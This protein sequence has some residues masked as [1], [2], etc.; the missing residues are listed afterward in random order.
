M[1]AAHFSPVDVKRSS[2]LQRTCVPGGGWKSRSD[3]IAARPSF[4]DI[5]ASPR[6]GVVV[7]LGGSG[8]CARFIA[9]A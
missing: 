7:A 2:H 8:H 4:H 5:S 3:A 1:E 6:R 9:N